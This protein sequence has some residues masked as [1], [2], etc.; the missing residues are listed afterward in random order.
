MI[1]LYAYTPSSRLQPRP[2]RGAEREIID[3]YGDFSAL[4]FQE[5]KNN[6]SI[7]GPENPQ[8]LKT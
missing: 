4:D 6:S 3:E 8:L 7:S 2:N 1:M 5:L